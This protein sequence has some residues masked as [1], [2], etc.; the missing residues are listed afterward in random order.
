MPFV[1]GRMR[2]E[3]AANIA[4]V[5]IADRPVWVLLQLLRSLFLLLLLLLSLVCCETLC[6]EFA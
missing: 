5:E 6:R 3:F 2:S 4:L 1:V